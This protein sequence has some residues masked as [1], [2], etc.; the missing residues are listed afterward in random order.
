MGSQQLF[1]LM[2]KI[3]DSKFVR[4]VEA[5]HG[6][7][8][9]VCAAYWGP[10]FLEISDCFVLDH[11]D[12][13][14]SLRLATPW[15]ELQVRYMVCLGEEQIRHPGFHVCWWRKASQTAYRPKGATRDHN[16]EFPF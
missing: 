5:H 15:G 2:Q 7:Q 12:A 13:S 10:L 11:R 9:D 16:E 14:V 1:N 8:E 6:P 3:L 4:G